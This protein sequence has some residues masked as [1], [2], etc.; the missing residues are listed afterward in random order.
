[1]P[2]YKVL[3]ISQWWGN[4]GFA[5]KATREIN[6]FAQDGWR[7]VQMQHGW[8]GFLVSTLYVVLERGA[9]SSPHS[10][11]GSAAEADRGIQ[12]RARGLG[13]EAGSFGD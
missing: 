12:T 10:V 7:V 9:D 5:D 3:A 8:N 1:M 13:S 4:R 6:R 11:A 2:E